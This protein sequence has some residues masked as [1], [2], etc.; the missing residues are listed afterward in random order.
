MTEIMPWQHWVVVLDWILSLSLLIYY[1]KQGFYQRTPLKS[2]AWAVAD[3]FVLYCLLTGAREMTWQIVVLA[4]FYMATI[5][6][7][8]ISGFQRKR[9]D[10]SE[11]SDGEKGMIGMP[12]IMLILFTLLLTGQPG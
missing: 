2:V 10:F 1:T 9:D 3:G 5:A 6:R 11:E 7:G 12:V 4:G 8:L